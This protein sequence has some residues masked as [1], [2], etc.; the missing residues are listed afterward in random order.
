MN[1]SHLRSADETR[2]TVDPVDHGVPDIDP[3]VGIERNFFNDIAV[4]IK[5]FAHTER[6]VGVKFAAFTFDDMQRMRKIIGGMGDVEKQFT[7]VAL[8]IL[9][10]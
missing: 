8:P 4:S 3:G 7:A 1:S 2:F 6:P 9:V 5:D 10:K